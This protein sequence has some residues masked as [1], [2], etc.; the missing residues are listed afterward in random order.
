MNIRNTQNG[1]GDGSSRQL[2]CSDSAVDRM[3]LLRKIQELSFAKTETELYLDAH[4][5]AAAALEYYLGLIK[6]LRGVTEEY[7]AK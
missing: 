7:E 3:S 2:N 6:Q 5:D 4:P 1:S